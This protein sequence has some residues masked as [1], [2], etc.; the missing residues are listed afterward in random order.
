MAWHLWR[1]IATIAVVGYAPQMRPVVPVRDRPEPFRCPGDA[2]CFNYAFVDADATV[3]LAGRARTMKVV[4]Q[5]F[6][7]C[8]LDQPTSTIWLDAERR[9]VADLRTRFGRD[10]QVT[11]LLVDGLY[12]TK[13]GAMRARDREMRDSRYEEH[14]ESAYAWAG[15]STKCHS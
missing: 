14:F 5:V 8:Y 7:H 13:E 6:P 3:H 12:D 2:R 10:A 9:L 1:A 4:S 11:Y 15:P